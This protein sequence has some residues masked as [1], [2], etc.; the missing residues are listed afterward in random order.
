MLSLLDGPP[1]CDPAFCVVW[2][3]FRALRGYLSYQHGEVPGV[4]RLLDCAAEGCCPGHGPA[5]L[6]VECA[7]ETGF[8]WDSVSLG[9][10][11]LG[12]LC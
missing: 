11:G 3:R 5:H 12:S 9:V 7:A 10:N 6:L 2:F 8:Q 4:S 1:G